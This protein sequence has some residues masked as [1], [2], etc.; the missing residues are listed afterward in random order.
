MRVER[1]IAYYLCY[2]WSKR[3]H[4]IFLRFNIPC[5]SIWIFNLPFKFYPF[6]MI[7]GLFQVFKKKCDAIFLFF[8]AF[9]AFQVGYLML[10]NIFIKYLFSFYF[11]LWSLDV[12]CMYIYYWKLLRWQFSSEKLN[13]F[14]AVITNQHW[15]KLILPTVVKVFMDFILARTPT[16]VY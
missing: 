13:W 1:V 7:Q 2:F 16:M 3:I 11:V 12:Y 4:N 15:G 10:L 5:F 8:I 9:S 14:Y 6:S